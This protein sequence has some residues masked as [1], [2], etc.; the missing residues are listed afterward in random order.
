MYVMK[1][2][3]RTDSDETWERPPLDPDLLALVQALARSAARRDH[4]KATK[5]K[6]IGRPKKRKL[7]PLKL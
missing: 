1:R 4:E 3:N 7:V 6:K 2:T 5:K